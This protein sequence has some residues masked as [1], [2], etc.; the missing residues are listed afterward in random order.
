[1]PCPRELLES[2]GM[3]SMLE[4]VVRSPGISEKDLCEKGG[5]LNGAMAKH[6]RVRML[7]SLGLV[8][9]EVAGDGWDSVLLRPTGEG[10]RTMSEIRSMN[11]IQ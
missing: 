9:T 1:M 8:E 5:G 6:E 4:E 2:S 3:L 10:I 11:T 7:V